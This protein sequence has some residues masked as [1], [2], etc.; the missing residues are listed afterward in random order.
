MNRDGLRDRTKKFA[1]RIIRLVEALPNRNV[2]FIIGKQLLKSGTSIGANYREALRASS[3]RHFLTIIEIA[4]REAEETAYWLELL[5][6]SEIVPASRLHEMTC[7]CRELLAILT[8]TAKTTRTR[9]S[10]ENTALKRQN[11][12][13]EIP[14]P[15]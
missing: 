1:L 14:N 13:S 6:E 15:K 12:K 8:A 4:L 7:E 10:R 3:R 11:P 5:A 9:A 2:G